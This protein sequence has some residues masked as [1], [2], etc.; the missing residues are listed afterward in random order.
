M[1]DWCFLL[2]MC[3]KVYQ[4]HDMPKGRFDYR[5]LKNAMHNR[6]HSD[7]SVA[8]EA[9]IQEKYKGYLNRNHINEVLLSA[10]KKNKKLGLKFIL[11]LY[12][13]GLLNFLVNQKI[14]K[15]RDVF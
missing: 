9:Y 13:P 3:L 14:I 2:K 12:F 6:I 10:G 4:F 8:L 5:I 1:E 11:A 7:D 15:N